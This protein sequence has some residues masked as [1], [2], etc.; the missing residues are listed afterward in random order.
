M[1]ITDISRRYI[2]NWLAQQKPQQLYHPKKHRTT[3][4]PILSSKAGQSL[5]ID[6]MDFSKSPA[7]G[8]RYD[9]NVIDIHSRKVW[10]AAIRDKTIKSVLVTLNKIIDSKYTV[11]TIF[12]DIGLEFNIG[13]LN[14]SVIKHSH[15]SLTLW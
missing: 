8:Y 13:V 6:L 15:H 9:L 5:Q 2:A 11:R 10:L 4:K 14:I 12:A 1:K 3:I 7:N